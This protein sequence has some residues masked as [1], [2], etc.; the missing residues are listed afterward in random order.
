VRGVF[1]KHQVSST[2]NLDM[3]VLVFGPNR[4]VVPYQTAFEILNGVR[5][6]GKMAMRY[7][8][9]AVGLWRELATVND[10]PVEITPARKFRRSNLAGNV[11]TWRVDFEESLVVIVLD[12]LE[13]RLH[14][15]DA[16]KWY[17][18]TRVQAR[19]A[20]AWAGDTNKQLRATAV[21]TTAEENE[22][23]GYH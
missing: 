5:M 10:V 16:F 17:T 21:L 23:R 2:A 15:A 9:N 18:L 8:G 22:Q 3:V 7:E 11:S 4:C 6:A 1:Q 13:V 14:Y 19:E 20:Q 12:A